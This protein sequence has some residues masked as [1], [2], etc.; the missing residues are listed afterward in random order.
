VY[1]E[2]VHEGGNFFMR[3]RHVRNHPKKIQRHHYLQS[4]S[5]RHEKHI[6]LKEESLYK[7]LLV[8][9]LIF[10]VVLVILF[11][12]SIFDT[13]IPDVMAFLRTIFGW[14]S[15]SAVATL[16]ILPVSVYDVRLIGLFSN[17]QDYS[18]LYVMM[19]I[20]FAVLFD[21]FFAYLGYRFTKQLSRLFARKVKKTD[22]DKSY[23]NLRKYGNYGM[24]VF[25]C[26]PLPFTLAIYTA[27]AVRLHKKG[28]LLAVAMGRL[29]KYSA[30]ALLLRL[31]GIN[32]V[33]IG[34]QLLTAIF[35]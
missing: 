6:T 26:T 1:N 29:V 28:F 32:L 34:R 20:G 25:A 30:F 2:Y 23:D 5:R 35:Q 9:F 7:P 3:R 11:P 22:V 31:F 8:T 21:T 33:D 12:L 14:M 10:I 18:N 24:F 16:Y 19:A 15:L 4:N 13:M 27:G 17:T